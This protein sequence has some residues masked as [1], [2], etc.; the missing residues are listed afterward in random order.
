[1][2]RRNGQPMEPCVYHEELS[3]DI[4]SLK[5]DATKIREWMVADELKQTFSEA[6]VTKV[7]E[8]LNRLVCELKKTRQDFSKEIYELKLVLSKEYIGKEDLGN[9]EKEVGKVLERLNTKIDE[10]YVALAEKI[11]VGD[12]KIKDDMKGTFWKIVMASIAFG[13]FLVSVIV[14]VLDFFGVVF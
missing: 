14:A 7:T 4:K 6:D 12:Q 5:E 1:V 10:G 11:D 13:G 2:D 8:E 9:F 3:Q